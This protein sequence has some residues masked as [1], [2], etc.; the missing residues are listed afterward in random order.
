[1]E[2]MFIPVDELRELQDLLIRSREKQPVV[3]EIE[4]IIQRYS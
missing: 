1:M 4:R 2:G 3:D